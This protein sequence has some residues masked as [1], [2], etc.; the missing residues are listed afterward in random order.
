MPPI[1]ALWS[2]FPEK[3]YFHQR[4]KQESCWTTVNTAARAPQL[5]SAQGEKS[6]HPGGSAYAD[7]KEEIRLHRGSERDASPLPSDQLQDFR[8]L[9]HVLYTHAH[10]HTCSLC[11]GQRVMSDV[12][13]SCPL[14]CVMRQSLTEPELTNSAGLAGQRPPGASCLRLPS[15]EIQA[16]VSILDGFL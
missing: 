4:P 5:P 3:K 2:W 7:Q 11:R 10:T 14:L 12:F 6:H 1:S 16:R 8:T 15:I 13:F 9:V